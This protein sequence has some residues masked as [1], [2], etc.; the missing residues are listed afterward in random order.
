MKAVL[1]IEIE[2]DG[3]SPA[4]VRRRFAEALREAIALERLADRIDP[5]V[6]EELWRV[7][8]DPERA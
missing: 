8:P 4:Q 1:N 2:L 6:A 3:L 7:V 5:E